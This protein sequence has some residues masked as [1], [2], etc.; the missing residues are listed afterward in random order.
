MKVYRIVA[1]IG[2]LLLLISSAMPWITVTFLARY[3]VTLLNIYD[4]I[5][6]PSSG[7]SDFEEDPT[8]VLSQTYWGIGAI[9]LSLIIFP[10]DVILSIASMIYRR[11]T[12][13]SGFLSISISLLW[14]FGL[15]SLK[16]EFANQL[17][18]EGGIF[19]PMVAETISSII[20]LG[21]GAYLPI[22]SG[23]IFFTAYFSPAL[24]ISRETDQ[25]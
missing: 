14:I 17:A 20:S 1:G 13:V 3:D 22:L 21:T 6:Q 15:E 25:E 11:L 2:A 10:L 12:I 19:G 8:S 4:A 16:T 23:L 7:Y 18:L 5:S 9:V 24:K